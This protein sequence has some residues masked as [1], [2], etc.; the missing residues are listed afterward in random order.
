[1]AQNSAA[2]LKQIDVEREAILADARGEA[3]EVANQAV[4]SLNELG[5]TF[6]LIEGGKGRATSSRTG[7]RTTKDAACPICKFKTDPLHDGRAHRM[8]GEMKKPFT[9]AELK[10]KGMTKVIA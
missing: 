1:M 6:R 5:F 2:R 9:V 7:T 8:Q 3:M 4:K 10:E